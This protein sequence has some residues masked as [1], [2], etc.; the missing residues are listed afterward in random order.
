MRVRGLPLGLVSVLMLA[1]ACSKNETETPSAAS[2][3][4]E[5]PSLTDQ[6]GTGNEA[7]SDQSDPLARLKNCPPSGEL[8]NSIRVTQERLREMQLIYTDKHP[9]VIA[10][11]ES[12]DRLVQ[13]AL[14]EC[15]ERLQ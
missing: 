12:L 11:V 8:A 10:T 14:S 1:A 9:D 13:R 2:L 4:P 7:P 5:K 6:G 3:E 15:V